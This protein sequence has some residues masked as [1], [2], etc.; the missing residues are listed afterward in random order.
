MPEPSLTRQQSIAL[1]KDKLLSRLGATGVMLLRG[2]ISQTEYNSD[3]VGRRGLD[4]FEKMRRS[5]GTVKAAL[6]AV[7][8]PV[9]AADWRV[10]AASDDPRDQLAAQL[11]EASLF[12][13]ISFDDFLREALTHLDFGFSIFEQVFEITKF[14]GR[15][16]ILL[17]EMGYR[18]QTSIEKWQTLDGEPG[19]T[20]RLAGG[21]SVGIP[22]VKLTHFAHDQEGDN[23]TGISLLRAAYKPWYMKTALEQVDAI[24]HEK[25][26]LGILKVKTP[27]TAKEDDKA[28]AREIAREQ[29]ANEEA[30]IE[31]LDGFS[32]EFMDMKAKTTTD[33][34][35]S[36]NY[37]N[38]AILQSV[39]AQFLDIGSSGSSG[40]YS[41]SQDQA[42]LFIMSLETIAKEVAERINQSVVKNIC[43]LNGIE[44]EKYP[45]VTYDRIGQDA[46]ETFSKALNQLF[47]SGA[48]TPGP[49]VEG[50]LR[51]LLHLPDMDDEMRENYD[52]VRALRRNPA[53]NGLNT[54][55][56]TEAAEAQDL[57]DAAKRIRDK[58]AGLGDDQGNS[59]AD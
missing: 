17:S 12:E 50:Y 6:M 21:G 4:T 25:Q 56:P 32:F 55:Q 46:I 51:K 1:Y 42:S 5:D 35:P 29:R 54:G 9:L 58:L 22:A 43:L 41:A 23:Y 3:L 34:L 2:V 39:L 33:I 19:I 38:R 26:G 49:E 13:R 10:E 37:H 24:K 57:L 59:Q 8:L 11:V 31:E 28:T 40:S 53:V 36:L 14:E 44:R 27:S 52:E 47:T 16:H 18:K 20:Q 15:E 7:K 48:I 30:F 45:M